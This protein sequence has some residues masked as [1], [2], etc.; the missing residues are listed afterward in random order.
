MN[1]SDRESERGREMEK[2][3]ERLR[4]RGREAGITR[5]LVDLHEAVAKRRRPR[6]GERGEGGGEETA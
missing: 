4:A 1:R 3:S 6:L 5:H 2:E